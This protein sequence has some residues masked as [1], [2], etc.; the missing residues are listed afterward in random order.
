[1]F[2]DHSFWSV[3]RQILSLE[4][5][6]RKSLPRGYALRLEIRPKKVRGKFLFELYLTEE[7]GRRSRAPIFRGL[8]SKGPTPASNWIDG[9]YHEQVEFDGL[10]I[11]V[12][13]L[14]LDE[15]LFKAL[16]QVIP[17]GGS[18]MISYELL[19]GAGKT[20]TETLQQLELGCP[21]ACTPLGYLLCRAG[22]TAG[23][24]DWYFPEGGYEGP[25]KLQAFKPAS[26]EQ[27]KQKARELIE[28]LKIF[29]KKVEEDSRELIVR[30]RS[31]AL[32]LI[33]ILEA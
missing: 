23:F 13:S 12:S 29:L 31:R 33:K 24:R 16:A 3:A 22:C 11:N 28:E 32:E 20:H 9:D 18:L 14:G 5:L 27:G 17:P 2:D 6:E 4:T 8:Y 19:H 15:E 1:M 25:R 21:P 7:T 26:E 10:N 30:A